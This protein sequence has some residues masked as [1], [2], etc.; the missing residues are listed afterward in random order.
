MNSGPNNTNDRELR[1]RKTSATRSIK[2]KSTHKR[3]RSASNSPNQRPSKIKSTEINNNNNSSMTEP[4]TLSDIQLLL[5]QQTESIKSIIAVEV[6]SHFD[7]MSQK[8]ADQIQG[9][10]DRVTQIETNVNTKIDALNKRIDNSGASTNN[11]DDFQR[12]MKLNE[13]KITGIVTNA[14]LN[15]GQI[16]LSIA[17]LIDFDA[18]NQ[19]N[20]PSF[21]RIFKKGETGGSE[22]V[23]LNTVIM[24]FMAKHIRDDFYSKYLKKIA[25]NSS[26]MSSDIGIKDANKKIMITENLTANNAKLFAAAMAEK[27][28]N[29]LAQVYTHDGIVFIK[30]KKTDKGHAIRLK[31]DLEIFMEKIQTPTT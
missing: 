6:K 11:E 8:L 9:I 29:R 17:K 10:N 21:H 16:F 12:M 14:E 26:I 13:L 1:P 2:S 24:K 15:I 22:S 28:T 19:V 5:A 27:R 25:N 23:P 31:R 3:S 4:V 7:S 30:A 18:T 20:I